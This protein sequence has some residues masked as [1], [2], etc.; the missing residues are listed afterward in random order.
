MER[1]RRPPAGRLGRRPG[2]LPSQRPGAARSRGRT[3]RAAATDAVVRL[4]RVVPRRER[5]QRAVGGDGRAALRPRRAG[6]DRGHDRARLLDGG[7]RRLHR[8]RHR[9]PPR[10]APAADCLPEAWAAALATLPA[11]WSDLLAEIEL[12]SSDY[13]ERAALHLSPINP[14]RD[15]AR[16]AFRFRCARKA[17]YGASPG[18]VGRCLERCD[19]DGIVG[20]VQRA[21]R[22]VGHA[23]RARRRARSGRSRAR[24]SERRS[25]RL[26]ADRA[27]LEGR[28]LR[29]GRGRHGGRGARRHRAAT[30]STASWS[31]SPSTAR[32]ASSPA[33][34]VTNVIE[35]FVQVDLNTARPRPPRPVRGIAP[36][37]TP[38]GSRGIWCACA[39]GKR[40]R[41]QRARP[42]TTSVAAAREVAERASAITRLELELAKLELKRKAGELGAGV[43]LAIGAA[44]LLVYAHRLPLRRRSGRHRDG[45]AL[46][47]RAADRLRRSRP[48]RGGALLVAKRLFKKATPPVPERAIREA[49][50]TTR[51]DRPLSADAPRTPDAVAGDIERE[52]ERLAAAVSNLRD[53]FGT[54]TDPRTVLRRTLAGARRAVGAHDR[55]RGARRGRQASLRRGR[56]SCWPASGA[57]SSSS[58]TTEPLSGATRGARRRT[59]RRARRRCGRAGCVASSSESVRSAD[60]KATA[61]AIDLRPSPDLL[62]AVDVEDADLAQLGPG[63]RARGRDE[64][65]DGDLLRHGERRG[66]GGPAGT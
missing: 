30:I 54:A 47:G 58:A 46:V 34:H 66:P 18:M 36:A 20:S 63:R 59:A 2:P 61:K 24:P 32:R 55:R 17:G 6:E 8:R 13:L 19:A 37:F 1:P 39:A 23:P 44:V 51:G 53:D 60:W 10:A 40:D 28:R 21:A 3:A 12:A 64:L 50:L 43:G 33:E 7:R 29:R 16:I 11:D 27:R 26:A 5:R 31:T 56:A 38:A 48:D 15:G 49:Q 4:E 65:A 22:A 35:G 9:R 52:R 62:A 41:E 57:S 45:A 42:T 25:G 14:R